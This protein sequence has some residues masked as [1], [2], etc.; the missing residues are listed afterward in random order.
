[1]TDN[2]F[3]TYT[4]ALESALKRGD[5]TEHTHRPALKAL[6]DVLFPGVLAT[7]EPRRVS[8]GAPDYIVTRGQVPLG[9]IETKDVGKPL[10]AEEKSE[11]MGRYLGGLGNL[12]LTDYL[13]FRW[14]VG[15]EHR[16]TA[17]L[18]ATDTGGKLRLVKDGV[19]QVSTLLDAFV[20][21]KAITV[22]TPKELAE[23]MARL[24][25]I[26]K[27]LLTKVF[28][29]EDLKDDRPDPLHDQLDGFRKVLLHD[30]KPEEF[31]DMY[32][33]TICYGLFAARCNKKPGTRFTRE[34]AAYDLP[35]TNPFLRRM[36]NHIAGPDLDDRI[37]WAVDDLA[38][39]LERADMEAVLADFGRRTRQEDPV[40]HFYETFLSAYDQK[41]RKGRGV[42]YTPEPVVSYIVRSID[43]ILKSGFKL[44]AGLADSSKVRLHA[45]GGKG[46]V[47]LHRVQILDPATG[48]GTF[49]HGVV[50]QIH[51][52]FKSNKGMWSGYV[53]EH[54][55]P[56]LF[57]FEILMAPYAV[58]HMKLGIQLAETGY[59][60][61]T[62]ERLGVFLTN[63]L[64]EAFAG[65]SDMP[66]VNWLADEANAAGSV[67]RD[68]P[69]MV[70]LGNPP[71]SGH[72][73]NTGDWIKG[74]L[75]GKDIQTGVK[76]SNYFEVDGK[77]LDEKNPKWLNDDYVKFIRF[78]QW[79]IE[80]TGH[81][82]LGFISNHGYLDNPTFRGMRQ[83]LMETFDEIY[84][85]D[86]HG[87]SKK[88]EK[89]PDGGPD[90]NVFDIQQ[91]VAIGIFVKRSSGA[92]K[93]AVVRHAELFGVREGKYKWLLEGDVSL[94][95]WVELSPK[96][97]MYL[98]VPREEGL[99]AEYELGWEI[100]EVFPENGVG[101]TT[102]RDS[103][104]TDFDK[105]EL[106]KRI[107]AFRDSK[108][109]DDELHQ[110]FDINKKEGW[111]IRKAW[112]LL[113]AVDN[114]EA[115]RLAVPVLYRPFD[116]RHIF[117]HD[118]VVWRTVKKVMRHML[119]GDNL[120]LLTT[121]QTKENWDAL[122]TN[123]IAAHK[124]LAA[125]DINS[126]FPLYLYPTNDLM[127]QTERTSAP[128]GRRPN[129]APAF[130]ADISAKLNMKFIP[131]G[132]GDRKKTFGPEDVFAYM[133]AVFHA[134][135]YRKRYAEFLKTDF[136]RLPLTSDPELF[137]AL[138]EIG[139]RLT[140]LHLMEDTGPEIAT[141][142][143]A[144]G[145]TVED[146]RYTEPKDSEK[147]RVYINKTQY[148][149]G[150]PPEVWEFHVG[151]YQV[152]Q[153]WLKDRKGRALTYGDLGHYMRV[154]SALSG[155]IGLMKE[156]D[157][158]VE[159]HGGWPAR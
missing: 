51:G 148:F 40:V 103:F 3:K 55:L 99:L 60:F 156:A 2:A 143:V 82:V 52:S 150:V 125:Y 46:E 137:R 50:D 122:A 126:L 116:E 34:H 79:R 24:A 54:L 7:N 100:T 14:Y 112:N 29:S 142:P 85:L 104:V 95:P 6:M 118:A 73:A 77:S 66:F 133:Y 120:G 138:C 110:Q 78:A 130:T 31:A 59:D 91:G 4:L 149:E 141:Y 109:G 20:H 26:I 44:P 39:L 145:N 127:G 58:A 49:L 56:R 111:S 25:R 74:L 108:L 117:W 135:E 43:H 64:E 62:D 41:M 152:C 107:K 131:D 38:E 83:S 153:K 28:E 12:V 87:N 123:K 72:S 75:K 98:F 94:T 47:E 80:K 76:T 81:G 157:E 92:K 144:G 93:P 16:M 45:P 9:Y 146:V 23:R 42:Y 32:A 70:V 48:T 134:P 151:G 136:P 13:E 22:G 97:P 139:D 57:G 101:M 113:Q 5:A 63:T 35:K 147:G 154:V 27:G 106:L 84:I 105:S 17:R 61:G 1:M 159:A 36:F 37:A 128:G 19:S 102:A 65:R 129:L 115:E 69:V 15:G 11:Q 114:K 71:Y 53:S 88:K 132:K 155:T 68:A 10:S 30:L 158:A 119:A 89:A 124:S 8:C 67:K 86:L 121:K 90:E 21:Q 140:A 18:A 96:T 33:Q